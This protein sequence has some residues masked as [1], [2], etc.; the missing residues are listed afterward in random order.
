MF[1][2][3]VNFLHWRVTWLFSHSGVIILEKKKILNGLPVNFLSTHETPG[4]RWVQ[5]NVVITLQW[6]SV[7]KPTWKLCPMPTIWIIKWSIRVFHKIADIDNNGSIRI[8]GFTTWKQKNP[9]TKCYPSEH[10]TW[11]ISHLDLMLS[12]L[13]YWGMC[14]LG[15][16]RFHMVILYWF[17][18]NDLSPRLMW[19]RN[20][21][22]FKDIP[23]S[24]CLDSSESRALDLNG[25]GP[26]IRVQSQSL[27]NVL[28][29][30]GQGPQLI[31]CNVIGTR[32]VC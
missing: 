9:G 21:R 23:S 13:S 6:N 30:E 12:S 25:W 26:K 11:H 20:K 3:F 31:R 28:F 18:L 7:T 17:E 32:W 5:D 16:L 15:D 14:Y 27:T 22:Q 1:N 2:C 4:S 29:A 24:T 10:W 19:C 8:T